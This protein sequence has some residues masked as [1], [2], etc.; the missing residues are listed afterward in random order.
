MQ[1]RGW[2]QEA[3]TSAGCRAGVSGRRLGPALDAEQGLVA[4]DQDQRWMQGRRLGPALDAEQEA[5]TSAGSRAGVSGRRLGPALDAEEGRESVGEH[6]IE[7]SKRSVTEEF[8][9]RKV[10]M[11]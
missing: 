11:S 3:W 4:G 6:Y 8:Q 7:S 10:D 5:G 1:S 9:F 2:W